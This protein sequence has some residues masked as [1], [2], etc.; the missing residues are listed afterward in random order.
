M[1]MKMTI[2]TMRLKMILTMRLK[3]RL[4]MTMLELTRRHE[5]YE[6]CLPSVVGPSEA[7]SV[8]PGLVK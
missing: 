8:V 6:T 4:L 1:M 7:A 2:M 3:M 5:V